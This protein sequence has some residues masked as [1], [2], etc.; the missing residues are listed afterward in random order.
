MPRFRY[1]VLASSLLFAAG[2]VLGPTIGSALPGV[3]SYFGDSFRQLAWLAEWLEPYTFTMFIFILVKNLVSLAASFA[4]SPLLGLMPLFS[5]LI[6]GALIG[7]LGK[8]IAAEESVGYLLLGILPHGV[9]ELPAFIIA[10]GA[11]FYFG[12]AL[13]STAFSARVRA[14][15]A[16]TLVRSL[17]YLGLAAAML[18]PAAAIETFVT[19]LFLD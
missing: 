1:F 15:L 11:A 9:I 5:L 8:I 12:A 16:E 7:Y 10:N 6:N 18:L 4:L 2:V 3:N 13:M 17:K 19:P 14:G